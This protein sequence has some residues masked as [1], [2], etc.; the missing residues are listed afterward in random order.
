MSN[1]IIVVMKN[2]GESARF[3]TIEPK[4]KEFQRLVGGNIELANDYLALLGSRNE[5]PRTKFSMYVNEDGH[6]LG[7]AP[8]I[9]VGEVLLVGP[10]VISAFD[11]RT[12]LEINTEMEDAENAQRLLNWASVEGFAAR[13]RL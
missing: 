9:R 7:L 4:L 2:P 6:H 8:N 1:K 5:L 10:V 13:S 12:G 3:E 11:Y